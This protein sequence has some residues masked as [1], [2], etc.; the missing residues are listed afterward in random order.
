MSG[1]NRMPRHQDNFRDDPRRVPHH[2]AH[3]HPV[4]LE[5]ELELQH[6]DIQ[7]LFSENR[8]VVDDNVMLQREVTA[9]KDEIGRL[10]QV[11]PKLRAER[12]AQR[13]ELIERGLK[14]EDEV[15]S[16]EPLKAEVAQLRDESKKLSSQRHELSAQI[17]S[18][19][20]DANRLKTDNKQAEA[21]KSDIDKIRKEVVD[22]R[23]GAV[24]AYEYEKKGN[25]E[26]VEQIRSME[27]NLIA[28]DRDIG[29]LHAEQGNADKRARGVGSY[30]LVDGSL[31][32]R[33]SG[34]YEDVYGAGSF[35]SY[36][37]RQRR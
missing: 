10:G 29:K 30:G 33:Y 37:K 6:R 5:E 24:R 1:R 12:E 3:P 31:E 19:T 28:M 2:G 26:L 21:M 16:A 25:E 15:R 34:P 27:K 11:I 22:A 36:D 9:V 14:L 4:S 32:T 23:Y 18:L 35:L 17:Q 13:R 20:K 8:H 7:R